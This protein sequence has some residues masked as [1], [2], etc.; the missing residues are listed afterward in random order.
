MKMLTYITVLTTLFTIVACGS[1]Q[2][3][4]EVNVNAYDGPVDHALLQKAF[5]A[6]IKPGEYAKWAEAYPIMLETVGKE[7]ATDGNKYYWAYMDGDKCIQAD[8]TQDGE[9][10]SGMQVTGPI[11]ETNKDKFEAC[12]SKTKK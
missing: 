5:Q 10:F 8:V 12:T 1:G 11:S 9:K 2:S 3:T 6:T 7:T 4:P